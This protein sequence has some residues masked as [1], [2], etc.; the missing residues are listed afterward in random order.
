MNEILDSRASV[1]YRAIGRVY[2]LVGP[3]LEKWDCYELTISLT[4]YEIKG[5]KHVSLMK[6]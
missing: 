1:V 3:N 4:Y 2:R 5:C 6:L